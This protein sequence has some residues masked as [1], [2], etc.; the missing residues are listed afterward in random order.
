MSAPLTSGVT[1]S[2]PIHTSIV[3]S[4]EH[5]T[6]ADTSPCQPSLSNITTDYPTD[7]SS[8]NIAVGQNAIHTIYP[9]NSENKTALVNCVSTCDGLWTVIQN[10]FD[11]SV[12][13]YRSWTDYKEGFGDASGEYWFGNDAIHQLTSRSSYR[14]KVV[15]KNTDNVTAY[16][17]YDTF[18]ISDESDGYRLTVGDY[19]GDAGDSLSQ[20]NGQMFSTLDRDNDGHTDLACAVRYTGAWWFYNCLYSDLNGPYL[21]INA[22]MPL[23]SELPLK[24]TTMMIQKI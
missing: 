16:A 1:D 2:T 20:H 15:L 18:Q 14:L 11:G 23:S 22:W 24:E 10:R 13:F 4:T 7:C 21:G 12:D 3:Q 8:F 9:H 5:T 6:I 19:H 17:I